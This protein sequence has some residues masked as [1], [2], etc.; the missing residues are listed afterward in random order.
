MSNQLSDMR[1]NDSG[2]EEGVRGGDLT[3]RFAC[4]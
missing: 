2:G 4:G 1:Y 3:D